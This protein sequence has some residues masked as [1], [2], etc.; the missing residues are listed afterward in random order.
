[1]RS[2]TLAKPL[3]AA[4]LGCIVLSGCGTQKATADQT[5]AGGT[6][7]ATTPPVAPPTD[8]DPEMRFLTLLDRVNRGCAPDLAPRPEDLP[9][10]EAAP[11]PRYG[12]GET[13]PG[14][15][16]ADGDIPIPVDD[17][18]P[19]K[20]TP[21]STAPNPV[22]SEPVQEVPLTAV[23]RCTG[24]EH[25]QRVGEAFRN[26]GTTNYQAM[27]TKLTSLDYPAPRIH[28]M[29]DHAGKPRARV[30]LRFMG[31]HVALEVTGTGSGVIVETFGAP[32]TEDVQVNEVKRKPKPDAP[33]S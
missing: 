11:T 4:V 8:G 28:R 18:V 3:L 31:S 20:P 33:T 26:T 29:P 7:S 30:D 32:E 19:S 2:T 9:G 13:P 14:V 12:P 22:A 10:W 15:P 27:H 24:E 17:P 25:A 1:M 21:D 5:P 23:E 6:V 16:N